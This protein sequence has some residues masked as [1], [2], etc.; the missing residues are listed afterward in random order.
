MDAERRL[1]EGRGK[2]KDF[3][4]KHK[5]KIIAGVTTASVLGTAAVLGK[6]IYD[7]NKKQRIRTQ[8]NKLLA[9]EKMYPYDLQ[10]D[11]SDIYNEDIFGDDDY[12]DEHE[13]ALNGYGKISDFL[14]NH[15]KKI[16]LGSSILGLLLSALLYNK[17]KKADRYEDKETVYYPIKSKKPDYDI[18]VPDDFQ[19]VDLD[20]D[21]KIKDFAKKHKNKIIAGSTILG[22]LAIPL[23]LHSNKNVRDNMNLIVHNFKT[24]N[25]DK[26]YIKLDDN[27]F[28]DNIVLNGDCKIKDFVKQH[29]NKILGTTGLLGSVLAPLLVYKLTNKHNKPLSGNERDSIKENLRRII[30]EENSKN[31]N[32]FGKIKGNSFQEKFKNFIK[33]HKK[34]YLLGSLMI[35]KFYDSLHK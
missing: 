34:E 30:E 11:D 4:K 22:S 9:M 19:E 17:Y 10:R 18:I 12:L 25:D 26:N 6:N 31:M 1:R 27:D 32:G 3:L 15:K 24:R 8:V 23:L 28:D 7:S 5:N 14:K 29:K 13:P 21:G 16:I 2:I 35:K 33:K 20:G